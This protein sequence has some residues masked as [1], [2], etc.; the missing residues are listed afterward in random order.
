MSFFIT[1]QV[2][3]SSLLKQPFEVEEEENGLELIEEV[4][5]PINLPPIKNNYFSKIKLD[6]AGRVDTFY[7]IKNEGTIPIRN[8]EIETQKEIALEKL[9]TPNPLVVNVANW[10]V[11]ILIGAVLFLGFIKAFSNNR[12]KLSIRSLFNYGVAQEI[13][14]EEKVFFH[15]SNI[16]Y[17]IIHLVTTSLFIFHIKETLKTNVLEEN[18][19]ITFL[20]IIGFLMTAYLVKYIFSKIIFYILDDTSMAV[21]YTFNVSIFSNLLGII[22]IPILSIAYFS[23]LPFSFILLYIAIPVLILSFL[24][25]LFRLYV[26]GNAKGISYFYIFLYICTLE[27]LPLVVLYRI[28]ILK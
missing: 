11:I 22:L 6:T 15:R 25:R 18:N 14:R 26:I 7:G 2:A 5:G 28:F 16:L 10:Q 9:F 27:I 1:Y 3:D 20:L 23:S 12:F 17:T 8:V 21:E 4:D 19:F 13:T 24:L